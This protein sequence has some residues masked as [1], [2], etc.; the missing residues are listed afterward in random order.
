MD[1]SRLYAHA[2]VVV[3]VILAFCGGV[4]VQRAILLHQNWTG[5]G[6]AILI[7]GMA[8]VNLVMGLKAERER[9]N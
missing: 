2:R 6:L 8:V 3:A 4:G 1:G 5:W 7:C 9:S